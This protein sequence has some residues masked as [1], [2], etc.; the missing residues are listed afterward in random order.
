MSIKLKDRIASY[1][2]VTDYKLLGRAPIII[3]INGRSFSKL[4][5]LLDKPYCAKFAECMYAT[6]LRMAMEVEGAVFSYCFNDEI[7]IVARN[8]QSQ[9]TNLW[10]DNKIQKISSVT[11]SLATLHF[12]KCAASLDLD[13]MGDAI[14]TSQVFAVPNIIEAVN[15]IVSKQQLSFHKSLQLACL[16][17][18]LNKQHDKN[19]IKEMIQGTSLDEKIDLL[20]QECGIDF[21]TYPVSF[22]RGVACYRQPKVIDGSLKNKW[23]VNMEIPIFTKEQ[24]FLANIFKGGSDII[25]QDN[26]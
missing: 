2:E 22:R 7:V 6:A 3:C 19:D 15:V 13:L 1:E 26:L 18:L 23:T 9:D 17:E 8:D 20:A 4:T 16:Y 21:N 10:Y 25:R 24:S 5:S 14:F 11:S 12:N